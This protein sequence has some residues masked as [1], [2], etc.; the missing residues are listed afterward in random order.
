MTDEAIQ[1]NVNGHSS[2][3]RSTVTGCNFP[4]SSSSVI[5][6]CNRCQIV[7]VVYGAQIWTI[8]CLHKCSFVH[9]TLNK[10]LCTSHHN[11]AART[12]HLLQS[13]HY[14]GSYQYMHICS[15]YLQNEKNFD[16]HIMEIHDHF[17]IWNE[18]IGT[19]QHNTQSDN[20]FFYLHAS[21]RTKNP[22]FRFVKPS[23]QLHAEMPWFPEAVALQSFPRIPPLMPYSCRGEKETERGKKLW[24]W[25]YCITEGEIPS[26]P[27]VSEHC[28]KNILKRC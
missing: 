19:K 23:Q 7:Y 20:N 17:S 15:I 2:T 18:I 10:V 27:N 13:F 11:K 8:Q 3:L 28:R 12:P 6:R 26:N 14:V 5:E 22:P 9:F 4:T 21:Y 1:S 25:I 16:F 24:K